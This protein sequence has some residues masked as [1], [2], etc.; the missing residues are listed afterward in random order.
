M[1]LS[2]MVQTFGNITDTHIPSNEYL[3][4]QF[5]PDTSAR[6]RRWRNYGISADFLGD[7]FATFFP[8]EALDGSG[9][10]RPD[11]VKAAVS[12]IA[13][14]LLENAIKFN[15]PD[16][17]FPISISLFL[18]ED[19]I[20]FDV[21]NYVNGTL[22][23]RYQTFIQLLIDSDIDCLYMEQLERTA[24]GEGESNMGLL[25]MIKDYNAQLGW[26]FTPL[27]DYPDLIKING[28]V[29]IAV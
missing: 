15:D 26:K 24:M 2:P 16:A 7:Y 20:L 21:I 25:T 11:V 4:L 17:H 10:Q 18:S 6:Q 19:A 28:L 29:L 9:F 13:N 27:L 22:A 1:N 8:G 3:T 23:D 14:E 12:Y 5:S